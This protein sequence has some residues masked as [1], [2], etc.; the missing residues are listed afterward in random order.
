MKDP[1][2]DKC[3]GCGGS[4]ANISLGMCKSYVWADS[5]YCSEECYMKDDESSYDQS[6]KDAEQV[7]RE[8]ENERFQLQVE[9]DEILVEVGLERLRQIQEEGWSAEHDDEHRDGELADAAACYAASE[10]IFRVCTEEELE[11]EPQIIARIV[12]P[13][14]DEWDKRTKHDRRRRM[15]IAA[16]LLVAEIARL[17]RN[18]REI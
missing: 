14:A 11:R 6:K 15:I 16:A 7:L 3:L 8:I 2:D 17:D 5:C 9:S 10:D 1:M 13:W 18:R 4:L 12:W